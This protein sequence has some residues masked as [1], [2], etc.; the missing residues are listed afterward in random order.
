MSGIYM[1]II[2]YLKN[3]KKISTGNKNFKK[4]VPTFRRSGGFDLYEATLY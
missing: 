4:F 2:F 1:N 3:L